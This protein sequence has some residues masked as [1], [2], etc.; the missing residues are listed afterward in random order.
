MESK[1]FK[2][3]LRHLPLEIVE[4][5]GFP[6]FPEP[7]AFRKSWKFIFLGFPKGFAFGNHGISSF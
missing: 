5:Q 7:F 3:F 4:I 1:D 6:G 2:D